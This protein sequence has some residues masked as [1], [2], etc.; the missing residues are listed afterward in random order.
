MLSRRVGKSVAK[1]GCSGTPPVQVG[2]TSESCGAAVVG[3]FHIPQDV[4]Q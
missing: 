2:L 1:T 4:S 3:P